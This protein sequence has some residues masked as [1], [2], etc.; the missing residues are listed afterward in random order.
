MALLLGACSNTKFLTEDQMLYTGRKKIQLRSEE[1]AKEVKAAEEI[2]ANISFVQPNNALMG[3]RVLPPLGLWYYNYRRP[4]AGEKGGLFY[5]AFQKEPVLFT[6][7]NPAQRCLKIE[8]ELFANGF[9]H[10][11]A[12]YELDTVKSNPK[13]AKISYLIEVEQPYLIGEILNQPAQDS[14]DMLINQYT[15]KL[16]LK[17]GDVFNIEN[18]KDEKQK[19]A[20]MLVEK[21]YYFFS[22]ENIEIIA[23][24]TGTP[25]KVDLL[26]RKST[27]IEP[28]ICQKYTIKSVE[29]HVNQT[30]NKN[31]GEKADTLLYEGVMITGKTNYLKPQI[32]CRNILFREN[33]LYTE[34]KH[35]G[36]IPLLNNYGVFASV[37]MMFT[38]SDTLQQKLDLLIDI[39]PKDNV[40]LNIEAA[41]QS[42]STGFAGPTS[43]ITISHANIAKSANR[44]QL[45]T[46]GGFEW[47][48]GKGREGDLGSNSY[49]AGINSSFILPRMFV[50]FKSI[51]ENKSLIAKSVGTLGFE[52]IN[53][54]R[55]YRMNSVNGSF[56]YLWR[57]N[58]KINHQFN[59]LRIN[60]VSLQKTTLEFDSIVNN[61]PYVKKSFE[62]QTIIGP[63]YVFSYDNSMRNQNGIYFQGEISSSGNIIDLF[64]QMGKKERPYKFLGEI[65]SQFIKTS[66]DFRYYSQTIKKGL[67]LRMYAGTG[68]SF[69][70]STVMPY[71]EQFY[72]GGSNSLRGFLARA[73]GPGSYKPVRYNGIIDQT[74]DIKLELNAEYRFPFTELIQGALFME[75]GNVW[76]LNADENRPGAQFS[77]NNFASQLAVGTGLGLR[78]DFDFFVL[79]TDFGFPLRYPYD[80]G[81]GNWN[82]VGEMFSKFKFN[83]AIGYPF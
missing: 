3:K 10:S 33:D 42:K 59:P 56:G 53:N 75:T 38:L 34:S 37:R 49:N 20:S 58:Q 61:N 57:K 80:D 17:S 73:L 44:I 65:Y 27:K 16:K 24:T 78:F 76:L 70:N 7:V 14:I 28:Y 18:I 74:G 11:K 1:K 68:V 40:S 79:R 72:S 67:V 62:E 36:T 30:S 26:I 41:I 32:L 29:V 13:K 63:K 6:Q 50:P 48:W 54:V 60:I 83:I 77:F 21:G 25:F 66:V 12:T 71:V 51:R 64:S 15:E 5:R 46:F 45:K 9:L 23:D 81:E 82:N 19:L 69:G 43:E 2:A 35:R 31:P 8:S 55:Y 4:E 52:F 39:N 47:Q 22:P